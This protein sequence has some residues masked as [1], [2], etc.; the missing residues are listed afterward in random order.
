MFLNFCKNFFIG[1]WIVVVEGRDF[2]F[3]E[4]FVEEVCCVVGCCLF[5]VGNE[6]EMLG[7]VVVYCL[8][9]EIVNDDDWVV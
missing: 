5:C 3:Y 6:D 7:E 8:F 9:F 2:W 1:Y 4:F